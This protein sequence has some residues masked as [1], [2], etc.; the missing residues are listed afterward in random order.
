M[1]IYI[2]DGDYRI[3]IKKIFYRINYYGVEF[4]EI[5]YQMKEDEQIKSLEM[6]GIVNLTEIVRKIREKEN[7]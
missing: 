7:E 3:Q 2:I 5:E 6:Y 4:T 1:E